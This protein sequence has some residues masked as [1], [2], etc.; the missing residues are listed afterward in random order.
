MLVDQ[1]ILYTSFATGRSPQM[2]IRYCIPHAVG[3]IL[4]VHP[5][6]Y[7]CASYTPCRTNE[8]APIFPCTNTSHT[9]NVLC[10]RLPTCIVQ[11][12]ECFTLHEFYLQYGCLCAWLHS[13]ELSESIL[14]ITVWWVWC[15][16]PS[17]REAKS[18]VPEQK[19]KNMNQTLGATHEYW[20]QDAQVLLTSALTI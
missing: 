10:R 17:T 13:T 1:S 15:A 2:S 3:P 8:Q 20:D 18:N 4:G 6:F 14:D 9:E 5:V 11:S 19:C 12:H 7:C 16:F